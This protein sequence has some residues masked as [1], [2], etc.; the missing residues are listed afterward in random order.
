[1]GKIKLEFVTFLIK[2]RITLHNNQN[3]QQW[4]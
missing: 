2:I 1:M 4:I 3:P